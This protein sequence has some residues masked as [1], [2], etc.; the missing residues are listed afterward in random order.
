MDTTDFDIENFIDDYG[1]ISIEGLAYLSDH[2]EELLKDWP[3]EKTWKDIDWLEE[4]PRVVADGYVDLCNGEDSEFNDET[5]KRVDDA[6]IDDI[7]D[8]VKAGDI[9]VGAIHISLGLDDNRVERLA[10]EGGYSRADVEELVCALFDLSIGGY[11]LTEVESGGTGGLYL[12]LHFR[13]STDMTTNITPD[14][15]E[16][17]RDLLVFPND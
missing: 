10:C 9:G 14:I 2:E 7:I 5:E 1:H 8:A 3:S 16:C 11:Y 13:R 6:S 15:I 12:E 4:V 17:L